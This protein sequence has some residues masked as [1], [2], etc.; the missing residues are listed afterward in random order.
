MEENGVRRVL[1]VPAKLDQEAEKLREKIGYTRS[2]FYR[3]ALTRLLE[4][5]LLTNLQEAQLRPWQE[6]VGALTGIETGDTEITVI[7]TCTIS[8]QIAISLP[9]DQLETS[10]LQQLIGKKIGILKTDNPKKPYMIRLME[11]PVAQKTSSWLLWSR[12]SLLLTA[13]K[14][15]ALKFALSQ[16]GLRLSWWF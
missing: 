3:Y 8:K 16:S 10:Q 14:F 13:L 2:G 15:D 4:Q 6:V 12:H 9:K 5:M 1:W 11:I 7:L